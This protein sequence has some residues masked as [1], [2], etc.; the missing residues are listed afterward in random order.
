MTAA[1][2]GA[3]RLVGD[4]YHLEALIGRGGMGEVWR[5]RHLVLK[6][7]VAIKFLL[8]SSGPS[9]RARRRF[10]TEAQ[11][12]ANLRTRHAVQ[13]YD[14]GVTDDGLPYL[15]MELLE[16]ETLD[17]RIAREGRLSLAT[18][19][20]I[21]QK[22]ARALERAHALG[23]VHRDFKP[24]NIM[25]VADEE[26][27]GEL[28]KV[29]DFGIAKLVGDLDST[30][31]GALQGLAQ[32]QR[33]PSA[34]ALDGTSGGVGTPYYMAPEQVQDSALVGPATDI[35]AFGVVAYECLT[36]RRP[37]DDDS[38]GKLLLRVL[39]AGPPTPASS[40]APVPTLF[41]DWLR[42]ACAREPR[43]RFPDVQT[44]ATALAVA[45]DDGGP[46]ARSHRDLVDDSI[47]PEPARSSRDV[48][49]LAETLDP[50]HLPHELP[51][52]SPP[53]SSPT[54]PAPRAAPPPSALAPRL[55]RALPALGALAATALAVVLAAS[56]A[57]SP[58]PAP[59]ALAR[60][61][62]SVM[63]AVRPLPVA[64]PVEPAVAS[65][66]PAPEPSPPPSAAPPKAS[67]HARGPS[68]A[69]P[70]AFRLPP[71]GL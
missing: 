42:V 12:T 37:F 33:P 46:A 3:D 68:Q 43:D 9:E 53:P 59:I 40:L 54:A 29:V 21:L 49:P 11:V 24:E 5:A 50:A 6:T 39:A 27:G 62:L 41:D 35:W 61:S 16:G 30:L 4:R 20:T 64:A 38:I 13:V 67:R 14:F 1:S 57:G 47:L 52:G 65:S 25:L 19:K 34:P 32:A 2:L 23:I 66:P 7:R 22:A 45:L 71:L 8:G 60:T 15:V 31:K 55:L 44:A 51:G 58:A 36:G 26:D 10:L 28:V 17:R 48:S 63:P 56:D 18:T 69:T 70:S